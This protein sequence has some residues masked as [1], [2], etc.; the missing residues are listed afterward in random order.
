MPKRIT[1]AQI[2]DVLDRIAGLLDASKDDNPFRIQAYR[3]GAETVRG[4]QRSM[5]DYIRKGEWEQIKELPNIGDGIAA[6]I[7]EYVSS[8]RSSLLDDLEAA[9]P[10]QNELTRV[11]GIGENLAAKIQQTLNITTLAGLEKAVKDGRLT[12]VEGI[13]RRR[14]EAIRLALRG[15][16]RR[17]TSSASASKR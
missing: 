15:M 2:A 16:F 13:G 1:N 3:E 10:G 8:G 7:G 4:H 9:Q 5:V 14:L 12:K 11:P 17:S 6:V